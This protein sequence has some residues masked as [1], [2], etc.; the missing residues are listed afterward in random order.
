M[1]AIRMSRNSAL[2]RELG[3]RGFQGDR[4]GFGSAA[5]RQQG[6]EA[7]TRGSATEP[8]GSMQNRRSP[9]KAHETFSGTRRSLGRPTPS[10]SRSHADSRRSREH[11]RSAQVDPLR[12]LAVY[13]ADGSNRCANI[14]A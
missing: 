4:P 1:N 7:A 10:S 3:S 5:Q 9:A 12:T 6:A 11:D 13:L 2:P 14:E 8:A